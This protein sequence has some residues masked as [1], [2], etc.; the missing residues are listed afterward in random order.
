M[1]HVIAHGFWRS[2][3]TY[4]W[5]KARSSPNCAAYYEPFH[6]TLSGRSCQIDVSSS[7]QL[8]HP[9][10]FGLF[11]EI[12]SA[13]A[14]LGVRDYPQLAGEW[15]DEEFFFF[16]DS[17]QQHVSNL[18]KAFECLEASSC[19][20][21]FT[22]GVS[23]ISSLHCAIS[24]QTDAQVVSLLISRDPSQ[25]LASFFY[26]SAIGN[27]W[28]ESRPYKMWLKGS[29]ISGLIPDC[30]SDLSLLASLAD[31][32]LISILQL[33]PRR[34]ELS[35]YLFSCMVLKGLMLSL[36]GWGVDR[37]RAFINQDCFLVDAFSHGENERM[38]FIARMEDAGICID[39]DGFLLERHKPYVSIERLCVSLAC[40]FKNLSLQL[41][42]D[43]SVV[44][45]HDLFERLA[46]L[47]SCYA[48]FDTKRLLSLPLCGVEVEFMNEVTSQSEDFVLLADNRRLRR[49]LEHSRSSCNEQ[50]S[51][52][53]QLQDELSLF[54]SELQAQRDQ[55]LDLLGQIAEHVRRIKT[56]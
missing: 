8:R 1:G 48:N 15:E 55:R 19:F 24:S 35:T 39:L 2:C 50:A 12:V 9:E 44:V 42:A 36:R 26:Q 31:Q 47:N 18:L 49:D 20:W 27:F 54:K 25:Q 23:K 43:C 56:S 32:E 46:P 29:L 38:R 14:L 11:D 4:L 51:R 33:L 21:G 16:S 5:N 22:R 52:L 53:K 6:W 40:A 13:Y 34:T 28:F 17:Q 10:A 3:S 37:Q 41:P 7:A 45:V 30:V